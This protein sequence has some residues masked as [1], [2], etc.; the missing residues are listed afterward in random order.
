MAE[1]GFRQD[2]PTPI[3]TDSSSAKTIVEGKHPAQFK[4]T[5]HMERRMFASQQANQLKLTKIRKV[6]SPG[7]PA[8]VLATFKDPQ[9]FMKMRDVIMGHKF[10]LTENNLL[11]VEKPARSVDDKLLLAREQFKNPSRTGTEV[12]IQNSTS[13]QMKNEIC[14]ASKV[15]QFQAVNDDERFVFR[16]TKTTPRRHQVSTEVKVEPEVDPHQTQEQT[17]QGAEMGQVDTDVKREMPNDEV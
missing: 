16:Q 7:N 1:V 17:S 13:G 8:D 11:P 12:I 2:W 4:G 6:M 3:Y 9:S 14:D 15:R 5:K 10:V